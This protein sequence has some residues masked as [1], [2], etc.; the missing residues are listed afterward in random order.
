[1]IN[2]WWTSTKA[3]PAY[4][5]Q[6]KAVAQ[7]IVSDA[8]ALTGLGKIAQAAGIAPAITT[9]AL[10]SAGAYGGNELGEHLVETGK[11]SPEAGIYVVPGLT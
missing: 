5:S 3:D 10:T 11:I 6:R 8:I 7:A 9:E 4:P 2:S 1:M